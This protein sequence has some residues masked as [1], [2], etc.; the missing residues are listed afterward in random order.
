[1]E[2]E[3]EKPIIVLKD[4]YWVGRD[5]RG[6]GRGYKIRKEI[7]DKGQKCVV[8]HL[9]TF[10]YFAR[11]HLGCRPI[12]GGFLGWDCAG[13]YPVTLYQEGREAVLSLHKSQGTEE[14]RLTI[15][16]PY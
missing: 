10:G 7:L 1:M 12:N 13:E 14:I 11:V 9:D 6:P 8:L 3:E 15:E 16:C 4:P 5:V 2:E